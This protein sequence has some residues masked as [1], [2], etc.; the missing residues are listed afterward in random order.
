M[1][2]A[3]VDGAVLLGSLSGAGVD[4]HLGDVILAGHNQQVTRG[5]G[6]DTSLPA[7]STANTSNSPQVVLSST[8]VY[9]CDVR[10]YVCECD[11]YIHLAAQ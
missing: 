9:V 7:G 4:V 5:V 2:D 3:T 6:E 8:C 11:I 10:V 1:D